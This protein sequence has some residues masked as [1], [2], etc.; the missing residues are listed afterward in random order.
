MALIRPLRAVRYDPSLVDLAAC[1]APPYDVISDEERERLYARDL[2]NI[3]RIDYGLDHA[4]D[5]PGSCDRYTRAQ[6]QLD[7]WI[8]LGV[9]RRDPRPAIYV[10]EHEFAADGRRDCRRG[11]F[12]LA[13]ALPWE[14]SDVLP[15]ER[16]LRGPREDRLRLMR[17]TRTQTSAV[18][19]L[20]DRAPGL[21]G[22]LEASRERPPAAEVRF[23][24]ETGEEGLRLSI[25]DEPGD[26]AAATEALAAAR[27]YI[28]DGHHRFETAAA[29]AAER[30]AA[31]PGAGEDADFAWTLLHLSAADDPA[32]R[33]L[34]THRLV[35]PGLGVPATLAELVPRLD[36]GFEIIAQ[37]SL[38]AALAA[39]ETVAGDRHAV[40]VGAADGAALLVAAR[41]AGAAPRDRL[42]VSAVQ[43]RI[44]VHA[45]GL[46]RER[47]SAG[48]LGYTRHAEEAAEA[49][50]SGRAALAV[51]LRPCSTRE[52]I[53][54]SDAGEQMPQKSTYFI[55]KVPTGLVLSP[56]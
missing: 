14:R 29:Y 42:D 40:A 55:P 43:E 41:P 3:V 27:L 13:R 18:F 9:L 52:M 23:P 45:C 6:E 2:R 48:A 46:D 4:D 32:V 11:I 53:D 20:Y 51:C 49:V 24:G 30:R 26:L 21:A 56:L 36:P 50:G 37:P 15:H 8:S 12:A 5:V 16:T 39:A 28:A 22:V 47:I 25:I 1:L 44:L 7:S 54:V 33:V 17:A 31:E 19:C 35:R 38:V 10:L 34:A